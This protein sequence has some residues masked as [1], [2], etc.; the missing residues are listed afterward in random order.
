MCGEREASGPYGT[1]T[2]CVVGERP[3][4][5]IA[6]GSPYICGELVRAVESVEEMT[7]LWRGRGSQ[8]A[9]F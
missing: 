4:I 1:E 5:R 7:S 3:A 8:K 6:L 2:P 9:S